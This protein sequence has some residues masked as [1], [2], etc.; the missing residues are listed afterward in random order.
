VALEKLLATRK[1]N[2]ARLTLCCPSSLRRWATSPVKPT[3]NCSSAPRSAWRH[4]CLWCGRN[5]RFR[6]GGD[7]GLGDLAFFSPSNR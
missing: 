4:C 6:R 7:W 5:G 1:V 3:P 2:L